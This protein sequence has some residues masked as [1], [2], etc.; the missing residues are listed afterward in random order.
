MLGRLA[1][2]RRRRPGGA[3]P[4]VDVDVDFDV[5][6]DGD[7][8]GDD[9]S[10]ELRR[11]RC[12]VAVAVAVAVNVNVN[13]NVNDN[14]NGNGNDNVAQGTGSGVTPWAA[15][16]SHPSSTPVGPSLVLRILNST[17]RFFSHAAGVCPRSSGQNSP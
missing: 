12:A 1:N 2:T 8:D 15:A 9:S 5:V 14:D 6:V 4:L 7:G 11:H 17:R 10:A 13:A 3:Q 16:L